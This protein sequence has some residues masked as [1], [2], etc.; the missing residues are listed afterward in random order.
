MKERER[1]RNRDNERES[2][3]NRYNERERERNRDNKREKNRERNRVNECGS[4]KDRDGSRENEREKKQIMKE[5]EK[6]DSGECQVA[7][8]C[9]CKNV[10]YERMYVRKCKCVWLHLSILLGH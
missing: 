8:A 1:E 4:G 3:R 9:N 5:K 2:E 10:V 7:S 6:I